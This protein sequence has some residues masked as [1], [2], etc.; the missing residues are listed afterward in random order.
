M[1]EAKLD[2]IAALARKTGYVC[3]ATADGSSMPHITVAGSP[4]ATV[5]SGQPN[6]MSASTSCTLELPL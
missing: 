4:A 3:I 2:E 6:C 5:R 1:N